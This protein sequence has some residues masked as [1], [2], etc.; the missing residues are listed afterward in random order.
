MIWSCYTANG[1][2][3]LHK[4][5]GNTISLIDQDNKSRDKVN[6]APRHQPEIIQADLAWPSLT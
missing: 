5:K 3:A 6:F 2:G 4:S 1:L